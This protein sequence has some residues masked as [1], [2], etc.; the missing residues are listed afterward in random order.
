LPLWKMPL[1]MWT[2][3]YTLARGASCKVSCA[4][5]HRNTYFA[6]G[7]SIYKTLHLAYLM[8]R[9]ENWRR[10]QKRYPS[11]FVWSIWLVPWLHDRKYIQ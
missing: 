1:I 2:K 4:M 11:S 3:G 8:Y 9:M 10:C 6:A 5:T 7:S